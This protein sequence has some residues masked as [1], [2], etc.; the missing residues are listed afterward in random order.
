MVVWGLNESDYGTMTN[1]AHVSPEK[2]KNL[3]IPPGCGLPHSIEPRFSRNAGM[4]DFRDQIAT[5]GRRGERRAM[6]VFSSG[7]C[8]PA[9]RAVRVVAKRTVRLLTRGVEFPD[10]P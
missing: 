2:S 3:G 5:R 8:V 6:A 1:A 9:V 4:S 10:M 7:A